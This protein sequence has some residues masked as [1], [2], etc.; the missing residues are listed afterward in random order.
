MS[1]ENH[2]SHRVLASL[3]IA[4]PLLFAGAHSASAQVTV[5]KTPPTA[6]EF[7]QALIGNK[8]PAAR[9][10]NLG[11]T[12]GL[13]WKSEGKVPA[14]D[15]KLKES[16]ATGSA[17]APVAVTETARTD[18]TGPAAGLPISFAPGSSRIAKRSRAYINTVVEVMRDDPTI[19]LVIEGHTDAS[20]SYP[21]NMVLSWE[22]AMGVYKV[23]VQRYGIEPKRLMPV[24]KG[25]NEP[26]PDKA[27]T[28]GENRRVQFRLGG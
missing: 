12:R 7:R 1:F 10:P 4:A 21:R 13:V 19:N 8:A 17:T 27:P 28:S 16:L 20:G 22:R 11:R 15:A 5:F 18:A 24:G 3:L 14:N 23:L 6:D 26:L 2:L 25:P 9:T